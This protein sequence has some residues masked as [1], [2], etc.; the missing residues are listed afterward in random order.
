MSDINVANIDDARKFHLGVTA[1]RVCGTEVPRGVQGWSP[2]RGRQKLKQ[3]ADIDYRFLLQ[4]RSKFENFTQLTSWFLNSMFHSGAK[5]YFGGL[6]TLA[7][8]WH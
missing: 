7:H 4:K 2:N 8:A 5:W 1:Q 3:F 6:A